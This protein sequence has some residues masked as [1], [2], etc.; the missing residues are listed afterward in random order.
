MPKQLLTGRMEGTRK[1]R[2][3]QQ[4]SWRGYI[5]EDLKIKEKIN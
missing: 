5:E 4:K 2:G 3:R 1:E